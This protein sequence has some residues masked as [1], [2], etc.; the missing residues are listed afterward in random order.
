MLNRILLPVLAFLALGG[1]TVSL[2]LRTREMR[3]SRELAYRSIH[4]D[5]LKM[6]MDNPEYLQ[7]FGPSELPDEKRCRSIYTNLIVSF[8]KTAYEL[9]DLHE[10]M[11]RTSAGKL[12]AGE[13]GQ[14]FWQRTRDR[15]MRTSTTRRTRR[16]HQILDEEYRK[17][18][19]PTPPAP[20]APAP[21]R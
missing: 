4:T 8:W 9:G 14:R 21:P 2:V 3:A 11:L 18:T 20:Q 12:F 10:T 13:E 17:A 1:M 7:T 19:A 6:A 5:L 16:F 15:R